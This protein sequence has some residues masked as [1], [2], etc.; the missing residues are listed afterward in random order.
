MRQIN[1]CFHL[2]LLFFLS[3]LVGCEAKLKQFESEKGRFSIMMPGTP[4][5]MQQILNTAEGKITLYAYV[6][7]RSDIAYVAGYADFPGLAGYDIDPYAILDGAKYGAV[8]SAG[9]KVISETRI[10][11]G[12][13]LGIEIHYNAKNELGLGH[14]VFVLSGNRLYQATALGLKETFPKETAQKFIDSLEIW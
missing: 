4:E 6:V 1:I 10:S 5:E 14:A 7:E 3:I 12:D 9:G 2:A 11:Y 13:D 8:Q